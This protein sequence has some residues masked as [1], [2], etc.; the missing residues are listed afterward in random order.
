MIRASDQKK[1]GEEKNSFIQKFEEGFDEIKRQRFK[2]RGLKG[3][4][5][6]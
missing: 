4:R 1:G 3:H 6:T 5:P 2:S